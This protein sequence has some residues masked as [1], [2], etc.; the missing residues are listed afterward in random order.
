MTKDFRCLFLYVYMPL[1]GYVLQSA[2][3][4]GAE[5]TKAFAYRKSGCDEWLTLLIKGMLFCYYIWPN[6]IHIIRSFKLV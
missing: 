2:L 4:F 1:S 6:I 5:Q 3:Q